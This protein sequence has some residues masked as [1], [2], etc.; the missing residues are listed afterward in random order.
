MQKLT[1]ASLATFAAAA[2]LTVASAWPAKARIECRGN[3]QITKYGPIAT[4]YCQ[5]EEIARVARS[6]GMKVSGAEVRNNALKKVYLCQIIGDDIRLKGS[7]GAY[8][9]ELY[10]R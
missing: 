4:P 9:R 7:C 2:L 10:G 5:E 6:F 1:L 8:S 3:F